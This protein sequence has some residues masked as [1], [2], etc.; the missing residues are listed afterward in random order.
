[1]EGHF[2]FF[3]EKVNYNS[4]KKTKP[5]DSVNKTLMSRNAKFKIIESNLQTPDPWS[6]A[7]SIRPHVQSL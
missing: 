5:M 3:S 1:M 2:N 4:L 7:L 6:G